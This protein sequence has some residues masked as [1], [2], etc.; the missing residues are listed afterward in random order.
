MEMT[1][2]REQDT[3]A[4]VAPSPVVRLFPRVANP[5]TT[6]SV[7]PTANCTIFDEDWWL[8][9]A[10]DGKIER[11]EVRWDNAIVGSL[12]Y[13]PITRMRM[14]K[15]VLPPYTRILTP[16]LAPPGDKAVTVQANSTR[17]IRELLEQ[18][19]RFDLY[20]TTFPL[21]NE[22][23]HS[24]QLNGATATVKGSFLSP[25]GD[26]VESVLAGM[27]QKTRNI[28]RQASNRIGIEVHTDI[29]RLI[30][31]SSL[32]HGKNDRNRYD[33]LH[34]LWVEIA[35]R[36]RGRIMSAVDPWSRDIAACVVIW[37][38]RKAYYWLSARRDDDLG[39]KANPVLIFEAL[40]LAKQMKLDFDADGYATLES[41][42][43]LSKLGLPVALQATVEK[44]S[45]VYRMLKPI[46]EYF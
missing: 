11:T 23:I 29:D 43:F 14:R 27:N 12:N 18:I 28:I 42:R 16:R 41:G 2:R 45:N 1:A 7:A 25:A 31:V 30:R 21:N 39:R 34:K 17:I 40:S 15:I 35:S 20:A 46:K 37:D 6:E 26:T 38:A 19:G 22:L 44:S 8:S 10:T 36:N 13:Y 33:I 3:P 9:A 24:F 4:L 5:H 32:H